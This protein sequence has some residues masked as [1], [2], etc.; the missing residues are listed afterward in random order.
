MSDLNPFEPPSEA[1]MW[2]DRNEPATGPE[3]GCLPV[4]MDGLVVGWISA[5]VVAVLF[6]SVPLPPD[7]RWL[8]RHPVFG[9]GRLAFF[10]A[11]LLGVAVGG[12][13][14]Q[15]DPLR[16]SPPG[17]FATS[18]FAVAGPL[19]LCTAG[20]MREADAPAW[21]APLLWAGGMVAV[22][23]LGGVVRIGRRRGKDR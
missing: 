18:V 6:E 15:Y 4:L 7:L 22:S 17:R 5:V 3:G 1:G 9:P 11:P 21:P 13:A 16:P 19:A 10:A 8:L 20:I 2:P 12:F 23:Y 14:A